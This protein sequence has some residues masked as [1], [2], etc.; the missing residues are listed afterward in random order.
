MKTVKEILDSKPLFFNVV[1]ADA[2]VIEALQIMKRENLSYAIVFD[3]NKYVGIVSEKDY[4]HKVIL[5]DRNL[6][7]TK[8]RDI[9]TSDAPIIGFETNSDSCLNYMNTFKTRYLPVFDNMKF[10]G[11]IT[12]HDILREVGAEK[13]DAKY[14]SLLNDE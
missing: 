1:Q 6:K 5:L 9:M 10:K 11:I 13:Q 4:A 7:E 3:E 2:R 14:K 8:V 12:M